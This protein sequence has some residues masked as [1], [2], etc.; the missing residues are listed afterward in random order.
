MKIFM[1]WM[2]EEECGVTHFRAF[3]TTEGA[4]RWASE[5]ATDELGEPTDLSWWF[6]YDLLRSNVG[7]LKFLIEEGELGG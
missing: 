6:D 3:R 4:Q 1:A 7:E 2:V 5:Q